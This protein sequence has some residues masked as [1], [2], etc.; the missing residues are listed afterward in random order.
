[1]QTHE[2][3]LAYIRQNFRYWSPRIRVS[4]LL[5]F[6]ETWGEPLYRALLALPVAE[7]K[8]CGIDDIDRVCITSYGGEA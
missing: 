4:R 3:A 2:D 7:R 6:L 5:P 8:A 1:M